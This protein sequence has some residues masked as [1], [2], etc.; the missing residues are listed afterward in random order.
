MEPLLPTDPPHVGSY[1]MTGRLGSGGMGQVYLAQASSGRRLVIKV[2]RSDLALDDG[3]RARFARKAPC[4]KEATSSSG[5]C[6]ED[7]SPT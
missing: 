5:S 2:I 1:R 7:V 6:T 3:F 4:T